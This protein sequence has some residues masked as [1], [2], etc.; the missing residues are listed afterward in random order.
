MLHVALRAP[1]TARILVDGKDV[2]PEVH[3]VLDRMADFAERVRSGAWL[4]HTGKRIKNVVNVG[5]G[6]SDL[7]PAMAYDALR[8]YSDRGLTLRFVSNVDATDFAEAVQGLDPHR[9][10]RLSKRSRPSKRL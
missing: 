7:G 5:I 6:G 1:R 10:L 3:A 9:R 4:G 2:V 8:A